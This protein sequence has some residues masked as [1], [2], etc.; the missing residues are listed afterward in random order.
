MS[1]KDLENMETTASVPCHTEA[2]EVG[3]VAGNGTDEDFY[4]C[5]GDD[6]EGDPWCK[7]FEAHKRA[8][9]F[10]GHHQAAWCRVCDKGGCPDCVDD[11]HC[12]DC[13]CA[14]FEEYHDWDCSYAD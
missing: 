6:Y 3:Q 9:E 7:D 1:H 10:C 2:R 13:G 4:P 5:D 14:L 12:P 8:H 11:P